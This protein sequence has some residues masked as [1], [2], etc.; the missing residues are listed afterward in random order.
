M[1][2]LRQSPAAAAPLSTHPR[3][4]GDTRL[5]HWKRNLLVICLAQMITLIGFA[6]YQPFIMQSLLILVLIVD[7]PLVEPLL[8]G[9]RVEVEPLLHLLLRLVFSMMTLFVLIVGQ[10]LEY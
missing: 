7:E 4:S 5:E 2:M 9:L 6:I 10:L 1:V 3:L 8:V